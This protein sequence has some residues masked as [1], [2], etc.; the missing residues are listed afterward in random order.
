MSSKMC[1]VTKI[2]PGGFVHL[3]DYDMFLVYLPLLNLHFF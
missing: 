2:S 3:I 1:I